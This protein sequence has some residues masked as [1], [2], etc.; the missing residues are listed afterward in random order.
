[1]IYIWRH[2]IINRMKRDD[3]RYIYIYIH[4]Y[5]LQFRYRS[6]SWIFINNFMKCTHTYVMSKWCQ[7]LIFF[8]SIVYHIFWQIKFS[9]CAVVKYYYRKCCDSYRHK[10]NYVITDNYNSHRNW[11]RKCSHNW[12]SKFSYM[13][14]KWIC[15][16]YKIIPL[17][18]ATLND[19]SSS[20]YEINLLLL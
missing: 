5:I 10:K 6:H 16:L 9:I 20:F 19:I 15:K 13:L 17:F 7:M 11:G 4:I 3:K 14:Y 12:T 2:R 18:C 8:K 1:M